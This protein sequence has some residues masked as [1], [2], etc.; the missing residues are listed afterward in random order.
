M[1]LVLIV[2]YPRNHHD[3][4]H[5]VYTTGLHLTTTHYAIGTPP[6][7]KLK[8]SSID[9]EMLQARYLQQP[10]TSKSG[11]PKHCVIQYVRLAL[12]EKED[13][14]IKDEKFNEITKLSLQLR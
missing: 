13:V 3:V 10:P 11:W 1:C 14:T 2:H 9:I 8:Y 12:V 5:H 4:V 6:T 7:K